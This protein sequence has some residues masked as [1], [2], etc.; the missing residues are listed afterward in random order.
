MVIVSVTIGFALLAFGDFGEKKSLM[1]SA[2]QM[3]HD[4][5]LAQQQAILETRTLGIVVDGKSYQFMSYSSEKGRQPVQ[6]QALRT[7]HFP[8]GSVAHFEG[9]NSGG[10]SIIR[11]DAAGEISPF[12]LTLETAHHTKVYLHGHAQGDVAIESEKA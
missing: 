2:E 7:R 6:R 3:V 8:K 10:K 4:I 1:T 12:K 9:K 5:H 11:F